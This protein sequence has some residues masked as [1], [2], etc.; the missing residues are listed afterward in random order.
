MLDRGR[1]RD[2]RPAGFCA[3]CDPTSIE[4]TNTDPEVLLVH[5]LSDG[6]LG[7][8]QSSEFL[9]HVLTY[10]LD[11]ELI[12]TDSGHR[13][14]IDP[15]TPAG[16][17]AAEQVVA[18]VS[19]QPSAFDLDREDAQIRYDGVPLAEPPDFVD[20]GGFQLVD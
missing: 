13:E 10:G 4:P 7:A 6:T 19:G 14:M 8:S 17:F 18:L 12:T 15:T 2:R 5:G 1:R 16:E 20:T 11:A 3:P 9:A